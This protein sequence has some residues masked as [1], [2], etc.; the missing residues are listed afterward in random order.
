MNQY[1]HAVVGWVQSRAPLSLIEDRINEMDELSEDQRA[2]LYLYAWT[3]KS[4]NTPRRM[5]AEA[6]E[7]LEMVE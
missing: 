5:L 2:A 1:R 6:N 7:T 3:L 4:T